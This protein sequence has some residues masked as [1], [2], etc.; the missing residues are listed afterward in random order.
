MRGFAACCAA[1][2][3]TALL[4]W[5]KSGPQSQGAKLQAQFPGACLKWIY[6][7]EP[8]FERRHLDLEHYTVSVLEQND[9]VIVNLSSL[10]GHENG[11]G[12]TGSLPGYEV[13]ISRK[14][15]SVVRSNYVR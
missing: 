1:V 9:S 7:A 12:S 4:G 15:S 11:R 13:E 2:T 10:D 3:L 8:E 14:D 6:K 5:T